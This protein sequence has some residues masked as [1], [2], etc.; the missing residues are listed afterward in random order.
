[1]KRELFLN[2]KIYTG[3]L[4]FQEA[5]V[6]E[7]GRFL[8]VGSREGALSLE[9]EESRRIVGT[10]AACWNGWVMRSRWWIF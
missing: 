10:A 4:P 2:G 8:Y 1:M 9:T 5:F 6:V 3:E 7:D